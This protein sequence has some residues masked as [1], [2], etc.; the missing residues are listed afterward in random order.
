MVNFVKN[1]SYNGSVKHPTKVAHDRSNVISEQST[2]SNWH[3]CIN[4]VVHGDGTFIKPLSVNPALKQTSL[5]MRGLILLY[6]PDED[7]LAW[8]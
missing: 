8:L 1:I 2:I 4:A 3:T 7:V 5:T 6:L